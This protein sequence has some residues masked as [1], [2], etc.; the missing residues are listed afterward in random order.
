M[1]CPPDHRLPPETT[2]SVLGPF[3]LSSQAL[4]LS[5][6]ARWVLARKRSTQVS[7]VFLGGHKRKT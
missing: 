5:P 3:R 4:P 1:N 2:T 7:G 6:D